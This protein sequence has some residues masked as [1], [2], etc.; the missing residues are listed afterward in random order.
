MNAKLT[1]KQERFISE[2][3]VDL[4]ATQAAIRAG[5]SA[6]SARAIGCENLA[7]PDIQEAIAKA[8]LER[9]EATKIDAE[10]VLR[11]A[12]ELHLRCMQEIKPA[13]HPKTRRQMTDDDGNKL[14]T[15]HAAAANRALELIGKHVDIGAFKDRL[16]V[17]GGI[18]LVERLQKGRE[19]VRRERVI[20]GEFEHV[21]PMAALP[22][23]RPDATL[24]EIEPE[25]E[26]KPIKV[27]QKPK[28]SEDAIWEE[29]TRG[30]PDGQ[31][32]DPQGLIR[33][34][35]GQLASKGSS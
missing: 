13:L 21:E 22:R 32:R 28:S 27:E 25:V 9:S 18:S 29:R 1:P 26:P 23:P 14:F 24:V 6:K 11:Q 5:Y 34:R 35:D 30:L 8:K 33:T 4:N 15:F 2:Y 20:D 16:E 10:W 12:V 3:L 31:W 17:S 7:K 19:R